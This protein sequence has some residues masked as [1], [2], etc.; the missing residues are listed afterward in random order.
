MR[1]LCAVFETIF[2]ADS[3]RT[4]QAEI[5]GRQ[6]G[7]WEAVDGSGSLWYD[8]GAVKDTAQYHLVM[9]DAAIHSLL[10]AVKKHLE[11]L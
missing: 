4:L 6:C 9:R 5:I 2:L 7:D 11:V 10:A 8:G 3:R 1:F